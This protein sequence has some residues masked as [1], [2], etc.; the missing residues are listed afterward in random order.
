M[1]SSIYR[2][3]INNPLPLPRAF[4]LQNTL[5]V[6][7]CLLNCLLVHDSPDGMTI[8][9]ISETEAYTSDDPACHAF[10]RRTERNAAMFGPPGHAYMHLNYGLHWCFNAVTAPENVAEAVLI[11]AVEPLVGLELMRRRRGLSTVEN[12][13]KSSIKNAGNNGMENEFG[14]QSEDQTVKSKETEAKQ[15]RK[16]CHF[17]CG[18]P[19]KL[20]VAFGMTAACNR[21]DLT[22]GQRLW[23][24]EPAEDVGYAEAEN[25]IESSR[26]GITRAADYPWRFTLRNDPYISRK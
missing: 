1:E 7:Q 25:I 16:Y 20:S 12:Q 8:G 26:I 19:G 2:N 21:F 5:T 23:L 17:L 3:K 4:Y 6:A 13:V 14:N 10:T 9:R 11:R 22:D 18:G 24:A 15:H